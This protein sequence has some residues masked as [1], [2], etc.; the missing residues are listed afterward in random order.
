M[1]VAMLTDFGLSDTYVGVMKAIITRL[2]P[3]V[4]IIDLSHAV[5]PQDVA[6]G[7]WHLAV[8]APYLPAETVVLA[9]VDPGVGTQ[10]RAVAAQIGT[11]FFVAPD[12][13]LLTR[14]LAQEGA[15]QAVELTNRAWWLARGEREPSATFHGR[16]IFA[17]VAGHLAGGGALSE[18]GETIDPAALTRLPLA[19]PRWENGTLLAHVIHIDH[20]GNLITDIGPDLAPALFAATEFTAHVGRRLVRERAATFGAGPAD[21]P[22]WYL[23][24]S[25]H[26]A[27][28]WR[29]D[30]AAL[31]LGLRVGATVRVRFGPARAIS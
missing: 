5:P 3:S 10:R 25:G 12:N 4:P 20:F 8:A 23:D 30:S 16:D 15:S 28:A 29:N 26:A 19:E 1:L 11:R 7:A 18:A 21:A 27:I 13:G 22:F 31:R 14:V 24:S 2:A 9:V 17:P 6:A